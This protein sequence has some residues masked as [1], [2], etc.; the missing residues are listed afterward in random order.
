MRSALKTQ[1]KYARRAI[2]TDENRKCFNNDD[3]VNTRINPR[4]L[5]VKNDLVSGGLLE[6]GFKTCNL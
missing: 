6:E 5:F 1:A 4:G 3:T 2:A